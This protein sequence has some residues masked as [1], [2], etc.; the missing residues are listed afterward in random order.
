[1][2]VATRVT[3][4]STVMT[5]NRSVAKIFHAI[6]AA[7]V[8]ALALDHQVKLILASIDQL[9]CLLQTQ[10]LETRVVDLR[11]RETRSQS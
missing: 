6:T 5:V 9:L 8:L 1:M 11:K 7:N 3:D 10:V 2:S 4:G